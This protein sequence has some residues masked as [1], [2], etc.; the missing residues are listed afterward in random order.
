MWF[1]PQRRKSLVLIAGLIFALFCIGPALFSRTSRDSSS[2]FGLYSWSYAVLLALFTSML[3]GSVLALIYCLKS[4]KPAI[5]LDRFMAEIQKSRLRIWLWL[6][7]CLT[8]II[9]ALVTIPDYL[10]HYSF[11]FG[12]LA[13][14]GLV[15]FVLTPTA[16]I[17]PDPLTGAEDTGRSVPRSATFLL[18]SLLSALVIVVLVGS[19]MKAEWAII[20][21]HGIYELLGT[22]LKVPPQDIP[23]LVLQ[24][25]VGQPFLKTRYRPSFWFLRISESS[26]WGDSTFLWHLS[27]MIMFAASAAIFWWIFASLIGI[28]NGL[29][30]T[31]VILTF[32]FWFDIWGR[33]GASEAYGVP[34]LALF[35]L[36]CINVYRSYGGAFPPNARS[37]L[38]NWA[39][40]VLAGFVA[41]GAK[42]N[43]LILEIPVLLLFL[44]IL[45]RKRMDA[46]TVISTSA[47]GAFGLF[48]ASS[49][50][51]AL[52][53]SGADIH[54]SSV[55]PSGRSSVFFS[56]LLILATSG[57]F[58]ISAFAMMLTLGIIAFYLNRRGD[59]QLIQ[60]FRSVV[61]KFIL[62]VGALGVLYLSQIVFYNGDWPTNDRYDFPGRLAEPLLVLA[63]ALLC[64]EITSI[65][66][67]SNIVRPIGNFALGVGML[68]AILILGYS[69]LQ[70]AIASNITSTQAFTGRMH[71]I[72]SVLKS[73]PKASLILEAH[74]TQDSEPVLS[75]PTFLRAYGVTN[76]IYERF[77]EPAA[78]VM[79]SGYDQYLADF[80]RNTSQNGSLVRGVALIQPLSDWDHGKC[81][82]IGF[83]GDD[84][85]SCKFLTRI[86]DTGRLKLPPQSEA[87]STDAPK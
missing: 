37:K 32:P 57:T 38:G 87:T 15:L 27:H 44:F 47:V 7:V 12:D 9:F 64:I 43:L 59:L 17:I 81:Y 28:V 58:V 10:T 1:K 61:T 65:L 55:A 6:L 30:F 42:E 41:I 52:S 51:I 25:E 66:V 45:I 8:V 26:L 73:N 2:V 82:S 16:V 3:L 18:I 11:R 56:A 79:T 34:G 46:A 31:M 53:K 78:E 14:F 85:G 36:A 19:N 62:A 68:V 63:V 60:R 75:V 22:D 74:D 72:A 4:D 24:T 76:P 80:L 48:V 39:L 23:Q 54:L 77:H 71:E 20:D 69:P 49:V 35:S 33:L 84:S 5:A 83:S 40:F 50:A 29:L 70:T 86:F 13:L 21:D 67:K